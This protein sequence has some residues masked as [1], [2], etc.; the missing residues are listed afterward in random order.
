MSF[1]LKD[2]ATEKMIVNIGPS[3]PMTHG[4][5][6]VQLELDG[7][8][9]ERAAIE[10]GY[11]HRCFEKEGEERTWSQMIPYTERLNYVSP[12]S[13]SIGYCLAVEKLLDVEAPP[14]AQVIR[15]IMAELNRIM[16]HIVCIGAAAVDLGALTN[17]WYLFNFR[18]RIYSLMEEVC[19][20]RLMVNY[21]RIGGVARDLPPDW[22][23]HCKELMDKLPSLLEEVCKLLERNRIM[24]DRLK[25]VGVISGARA[26]AYGFT[27]PCL[28]A[29]GVDLD[30]RRDE[31]YMGYQNYDF[32]VCV[33]NGGDCYDRLFIRFDEMRESHK[34]VMQALQKLPG[35]DFLLRNPKVALPPKA[36]VYGSIEGL[37][38]H[39]K[40][41]FEGI[42]PPKGEVYSA[43]EAVN[44]E[45]GYYLVSDGDGKAY[46]LHCRAPCFPIFSALD[47]LTRGHMVADVVAIIGGLN[48]VA[49]ELER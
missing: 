28:R 4:T 29:S 11:L 42:R 8:R 12:M 46:R 1:K 27:G 15:V 26:I 10:I 44:G 24:V 3:H 43:T 14:R 30:L 32:K 19:G 37:V 39:F 34:I 18:E 40:L 36:E 33:R 47:E 20:A 38:N 41:I 23:A 2:I 48:I 16:D 21:P 7:E 49:G 35:G 17:F 22:V 25:D 5:L 13:N 45:L 9:V 6:R 31:P